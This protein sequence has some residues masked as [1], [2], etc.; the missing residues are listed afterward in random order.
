MSIVL[1]KLS[2]GE[3]IANFTPPTRRRI[4]R[5][6]DDIVNCYICDKTSKRKNTVTVVRY[7]NTYTIY[8]NFYYYDADDLE[9]SLDMCSGCLPTYIN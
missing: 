9:N 8:D 5:S 1:K 3:M 2:E 7:G 6:G 4:T